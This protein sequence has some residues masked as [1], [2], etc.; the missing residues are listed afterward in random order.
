MLSFFLK[1][2]LEVQVSGPY[3]FQ[4]PYSHQVKFISFG[5]EIPPNENRI[6]HLYLRD[7]TLGQLI[8]G[9][10]V[11]SYNRLTN[12]YKIKLSFHSFLYVLK[13]Y[14]FD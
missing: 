2:Y 12:K 1:K 6:P 5:E 3:I 10:I 9:T 13:S 14:K 4:R 7:L 8:V 11:L